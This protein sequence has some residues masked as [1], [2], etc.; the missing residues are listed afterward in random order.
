M[1]LSEK[2]LKEVLSIHSATKVSESKKKSPRKSP[3]KSPTRKKEDK[4][5]KKASSVNVMVQKLF[6]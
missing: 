3:R 4:P 5:V 2:I 1:H 6:Q